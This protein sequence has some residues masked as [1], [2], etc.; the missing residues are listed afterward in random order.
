MPDMFGRPMFIL[1]TLSFVLG[2]CILS[3]IEFPFLS[4]PHNIMHLFFGTLGIA[5]GLPEVIIL[6]YIFRY[7]LTKGGTHHDN[8]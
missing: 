7:F 8:H 4:N 3:L 6:I 1:G 2:L 5:I